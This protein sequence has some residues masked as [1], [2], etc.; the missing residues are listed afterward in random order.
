MIYSK[1]FL[2]IGKSDAGWQ[3]VINCLSAFLWTGIIFAF[4]ILWGMTKFRCNGF[5][6]EGAQSFIMQTKIS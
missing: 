5:D 2:S 1:T 6:I 4:P 3:F